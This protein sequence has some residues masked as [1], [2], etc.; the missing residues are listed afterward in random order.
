[1]KNAIVSFENVNDKLVIA[2]GVE[3]KDNEIKELV[4]SKSLMDRDRQVSN[5]EITK[6]AEG[7]SYLVQK[8]LTNLRKIT[9]SKGHPS[10]IFQKV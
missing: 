3:I 2:E 7:L 6:I 5:R 4:N 1:M 8:L 9:N 10:P